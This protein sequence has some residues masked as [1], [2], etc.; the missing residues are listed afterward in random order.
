MADE[1][2]MEQED[3]F[4]SFRFAMVL[5]S[6]LA[7]AAAFFAWQGASRT[8]GFLSVAGGVVL[9]AGVLRPEAIRPLERAWEA[10]RRLLTTACEGVAGRILEVLK[11]IPRG[12]SGRGEGQG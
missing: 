9:G 2:F 7:A 1:G 6:A 12:V 8:A 5:G 4:E 3:G 11:A 10:A